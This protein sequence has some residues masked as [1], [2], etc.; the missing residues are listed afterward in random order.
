[1]RLY[2]K[3]LRDGIFEGVHLKVAT[4]LLSVH[5]GFTSIYLAMKNTILE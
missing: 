3:K 2:K 5:C 1:M 4:T